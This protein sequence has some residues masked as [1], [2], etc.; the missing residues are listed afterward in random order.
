MACKGLLVGGPPVKVKDK[1]Q[2]SRVWVVEPLASQ[3]AT[4]P[5]RVQ[6]S[7]GATVFAAGDVRI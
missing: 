6:E 3:V 4:R 2:E 5:D 7:L 1:S